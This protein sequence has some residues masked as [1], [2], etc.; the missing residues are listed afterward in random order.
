MKRFFKWAAIVV[1]ALILLLILV[2]GSF[3]GWLKW[4]G[5]RDWKRAE[6]ELRAK[7]EKL[8]F[9]ELVP[10]MPPDSENFFADPLWAEYADLVQRKNVQGLDEWVPRLRSDQYQLQRWQYSLLAPEEKE[11]LIKLIPSVKGINNR[12]EAFSLLR[13][14]LDQEKDLQKQRE[15]A[16]LLLDVVAPADPVLIHVAKLS[17][18]PKAQFPIR[19]DLGPRTP[20]PQISAIMS[21]AQIINRK[22][23]SEL[24]L[25][26]IKEAA[27]DTQTLLRLSS[28]V[29]NDPMLISF[30]VRVSSVTLA[31]QPINEG[32]LRH[33]WTAADLNS[34]QERLNRLHL[35]EGILTALKGERAFFNQCDSA[36]IGAELTCSSSRS[37]L[38]EKMEVKLNQLCFQSIFI[39]DK[40]FQNLWFQRNVETLNSNISTGWNATSAQSADQEITALAKNPLNRIIYALNVISSSA[41]ASCC[42]KAVECQTQADQTL[43][44]CALER[45]RLARGSYP[46][47]LEALVPEYLAKLPNSPITGKPMNYSPKPDGTFLLWSPGWNLKSLGGKPGEFL[48]EGDI[49]WGQPLP[50]LSR[51]KPKASE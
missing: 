11:R 21:L 9:A 40:A 43:I 29:K 41:I 25:G 7:G 48:G 23:L 14:K 36:L 33:S 24:I 28:I 8:T 19:Y 46:S 39:K 18:R 5:E 38:L 27:T 37:N 31:L 51:E 26:K 1:S 42:L 32:I 17:E 30:L 49:V 50:K 35:Q 15:M 34:F 3:I 10:P 44:A 22:A 12:K 6:A 2:I 13:A 16:A 4:S 47:S 20:L 45:Y